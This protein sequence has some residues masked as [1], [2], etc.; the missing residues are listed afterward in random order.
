MPLFRESNPGG[1]RFFARPDRPWGP[2]SLLYNGY[3]VFP[4]AK[5]DRGVLLTTH[6]L[7]VPWS[8][9][10]RAIPPTTLWATTGPVTGT[11]YLS[12]MPVLLKFNEIR[13]IWYSH[14]SLRNCAVLLTVYKAVFAILLSSKHSAHKYTFNSTST[15]RHDSH[16]YK[17]DNSPFDCVTGKQ[18]CITHLITFKKFGSQGTHP[19]MLP[20]L[21]SPASAALWEQCTHARPPTQTH[22]NTTQSTPQMRRSTRILC[23]SSLHVRNIKKDSASNMSRNIK[24]II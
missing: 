6:P 1:A 7:L 4:G 17:A 13:P 15:S 5:Y 16:I 3:R 20:I 9:K 21:T 24:T 2:P 23:T 8:W 19:T 11:L 12:T 14:W 10:S 18:A 22:R